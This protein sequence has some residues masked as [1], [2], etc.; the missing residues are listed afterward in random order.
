MSAVDKLTACN[1]ALFLVG[2]RSLGALTEENERARACNQYID[3]VRRELI[4]ER[5]WT[6]ARKHVLLDTPDATSP[7]HFGNR[8]ELPSDFLS[9][10]KVST[11]A[12]FSR[13]NVPYDME[14][15]ATAKFIA[16][17]ADQ[18]YIRY[19]FDQQNFDVMNPVF[20]SAVSHRLA[21]YLAT[22]LTSSKTLSEKLMVVAE[23]KLS[24]AAAQ[25]GRQLPS[26]RIRSSTFLDVR[27]TRL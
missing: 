6:F 2:E 3:Q 7:V 12:D 11:D 5:E 19:I 22:L 10:K 4:S 14:S 15:T 21:S 17:D 18:I 8:F 16:T 13:H 1:Q 26:E 23:Q 24:E 9:L 25:D 27:T 20:I